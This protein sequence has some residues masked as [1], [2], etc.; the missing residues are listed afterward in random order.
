MTVRHGYPNKAAQ[1]MT[2]SELEVT[3]R[4]LW[5]AIWLLHRMRNG[6]PFM[7]SIQAPPVGEVRLDRL[8]EWMC[9]D[10]ENYSW[11]ADLFRC[12]WFELRRRK[13]NLAGKIEEELRQQKNKTPIIDGWISYSCHTPSN[14]EASRKHA[15]NAPSERVMSFAGFPHNPNF[16]SLNWCKKEKF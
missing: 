6:L 3:F 4:H 15:A 12:V 7:Q 5:K 16:A 13:P 11:S 1:K 2:T 9:E 8:R 14:L 10:R